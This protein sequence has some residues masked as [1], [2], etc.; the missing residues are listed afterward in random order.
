M[1]FYMWFEDTTGSGERQVESF[2]L[3]WVI[4]SEHG[5]LQIGKTHVWVWVGYMTIKK[6]VNK[7]PYNLKKYNFAFITCITYENKLVRLILL[8]QVVFFCKMANNVGWA[9][10]VILTYSD[11]ITEWACKVKWLFFFF[12]I[13]QTPLCW[14]MKT[15][16]NVFLRAA[17]SKTRQGWSE[18]PLHSQVVKL[19]VPGESLF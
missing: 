11:F 9:S 13:V 6:K 16:T 10:L 17:R 15:F 7:L 14:L 5:K 19:L 1:K 8:Q 3:N 2:R 18:F 12:T 4:W